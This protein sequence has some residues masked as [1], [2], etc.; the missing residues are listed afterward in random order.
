M[1]KINIIWI[2][3]FAIFFVITSCSAEDDNEV[4]PN[5]K[6]AQQHSFTKEVHV[7]IMGD[8]FSRDAFGYV[9]GVMADVRPEIYLDME[10]LYLG[11]K[12]LKYHWDYISN[13]KNNFILDE[14]SPNNDKWYSYANI[15]GGDIISSQNWDLVIL[16]E[17][18]STARNSELTLE[19]VQTIG[20]YLR[21][22]QPSVKLAFML[23]PAK[24]E[25][26][27]AL[28][29]Y[30]SDDVWNLYVKTSQLLLA[31]NAVD[32]IIPCGTAIQNARQTSVDNYG[33]FGHLS[34]DG[35]HLQEG[36]PCLIEA[37]VG[38]QFLLDFIEEDASIESSTLRVTKQWVNSLA[39]P[40]M[41][42]S[43]IEGND[44]EYAICKRSAMSALEK[45]YEISNPLY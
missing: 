37:Y 39:V 31:N 2:F 34:Y 17:G 42:G 18:S 32:Y 29:N 20:S 27:P 13:D 45:P 11:G 24:P 41:H 38:T 36:L 5:R 15:F 40:G 30:T 8:S 44:E 14:Y 28:G 35:N 1:K 4:K 19:H 16:Q 7:L 23:S 12:G 3:T 25:G 43:V 21:E 26:S 33:D 10:L 22:R 6:E 9:P